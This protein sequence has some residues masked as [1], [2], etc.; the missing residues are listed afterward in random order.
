MKILLI[1]LSSLGDLIHAF[2]ALSDLQ[3][4]YPD[5]Q[6][7]WVVEENFAEV[8]SWHPIVKEVIPISFRRIKKQGCW[9]L[10]SLQELCRLVKQLRADRYDFIIDAQGLYKSAGLGF[11]ARG[12]RYGFAKQSSREQVS[13]LYQQKIGVNKDAHA[14]K[15]VRDLFSQTF[16]YHY[17]PDLIDYQIGS[18][19]GLDSKALVFVH[20]TTW[21]TKHYPETYW[22]KLAQFAEDNVWQV[23]LPQINAQEQARAILIAQGL[24][25]V[26]VLP[27]M[28]LTAIKN[29]LATV[30]AIISVDTG[31]AHI[32][33]ALGVPALTLYGPTNPKHIGAIGAHQ[34]HLAAD[35]VCAPCVQ[36]ICTH[37]LRGH[38][39]NPPCFSSIA[40]AEVWKKFSQ[41][42][43]KTEHS[44][45]G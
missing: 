40:P 5:A 17:D 33:A 28:S 36:K 22:H 18:W 39:P 21:A 14:I 4:H 31:L 3:K 43:A 8:P 38:G 32:A 1:K 35:F 6:V 42:L 23:E 25:A 30:R 7:D 37:P 11:L 41:L 10:K 24:S 26:T 20:A 2:P 44:G 15:R 45:I 27:K 34:E 13:W 16:N 12:R 19:Q 9:R 29:H